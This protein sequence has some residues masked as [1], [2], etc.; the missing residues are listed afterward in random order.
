MI[1]AIVPTLQNYVLLIFPS[2]LSLRL[3]CAQ[4][5]QLSWIQPLSSLVFSLH[6]GSWMEV[7]MW[8]ILILLYSCQSTEKWLDHPTKYYSRIFHI[9]VF[10]GVQQLLLFI[11]P[12]LGLQM[13]PSTLLFHTDAVNTHSWSNTRCIG[14]FVNA[15]TA[16]LA[17]S[18]QKY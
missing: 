12:G 5:G 17:S 4:P 6:T 14:C 7:G 1:I 10:L 16:L 15:I 2:A 13:P 9:F 18:K 11:P 8:E 3:L